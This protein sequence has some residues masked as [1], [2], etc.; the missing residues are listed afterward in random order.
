[1]PQLIKDRA[2][3]ED[4]YVLARDAAALADVPAAPAIVPLALWR[5][6]RGALLARG[7]VG[8]LLGPADDPGAIAEDAA[9][10]PVIAVDF[11]KFTDGRGY[12]IARLLRERHGYRGEL[13][14]VGDVLRDQLFALSQC[15]FDAFAL[16]ADCDAASALASLDDFPGV[17]TA[18][19]RTPEPWF[20]RRRAA[21][22]PDAT[23][24]SFSARG[25]RRSRAR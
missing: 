12:S 15:G 22:D 17:Y 14:A 19:T 25:G 8:V 13:R 4:R 9:T 18:T 16:R 2:L 23:P 3:A 7:N 6:E 20:R 1:M 5:A 24:R 11:P 10:V 21:R